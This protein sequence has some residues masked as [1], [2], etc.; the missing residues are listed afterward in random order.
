LA[1]ALLALPPHRFV[2]HG[3]GDQIRYFY[4]EPQHCS[5]ILIGTPGR[6]RPI[7]TCCASRCSSPTTSLPII[8]TRRMLLNGD[9]VYLDSLQLQDPQTLTD[10]FSV[11]Y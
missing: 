2:M 6:I 10:Y 1:R 9:P 11:Y 3:I 8:A 7:V 4:A 5:C